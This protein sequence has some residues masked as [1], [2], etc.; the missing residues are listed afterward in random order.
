MR[1]PLLRFDAIPPPIPAPRAWIAKATAMLCL[2][3]E[4]VYT[5]GGP[6]PACASDEAMPLAR[7]TDRPTNIPDGEEA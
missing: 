1:L 3:C 5:A 7:V 2:D 4:A 6:C